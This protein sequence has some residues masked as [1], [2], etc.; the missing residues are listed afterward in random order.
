MK[1]CV[2]YGEAINLILLLESNLNADDVESALHDAFMVIRPTLFLNL[3]ASNLKLD[4]ADGALQCC[5][6]AIQLCNAPG[7]PYAD[8]ASSKDIEFTS[9]YRPSG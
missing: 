3:A 7:L 2:L 1:A 5:N 9:R 6:S 8:L 4:A